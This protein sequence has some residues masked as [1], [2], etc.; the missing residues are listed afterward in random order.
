MRGRR[1]LAAALLLAATE[2]G[3]QPIPAPPGLEGAACVACRAAP[4]ELRGALDESAWRGLL[5]GSV[6][7]HDDP[8]AAAAGERRLS[9]LGIARS[10]PERVWAVLTDWPNYA[11][12]LPNTVETRVRRIERRS[13]WLSQHLRVFWS[14]VRFGVRWDLEPERG[15]LRFGLDPEVPHDIAG[16]QGA[17]RLA[18]LEDGSVTLLRYE[19]WVDPGR[20]V[21]GFVERAL[22]R[23]SLPKVVG[24]VCREVER[25]FP[26]GE[27]H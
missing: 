3:A 24:S 2:A 21:P 25:R 13:A 17:W 18:P 1:A 6:V 20:A 8:A 15:L 5:A 12:F 16:T 23:R 14:D 11:S 10:R 9:A 26:A 27:P 22:T 19:V 7:T 4:E